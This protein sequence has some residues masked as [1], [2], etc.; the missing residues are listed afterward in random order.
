MTLKSLPIGE[1][2]KV[3]VVGGQGALRRRLLDMGITPGTVVN[4]RKVAPM[5]DPIELKLRGY[6][7]TIRLED[8]EKIE[9]ERMDGC[10]VCPYR[11][12][13]LR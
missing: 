7:L 9:I 1:C 11:E 3:T 10:D 13:K 4:V 6:I 8:A 5:G 2:G 12:S